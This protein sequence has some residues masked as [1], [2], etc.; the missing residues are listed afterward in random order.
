MEWKEV[1]PSDKQSLCR[2]IQ[3]IKLMITNKSRK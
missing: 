3:I 2:I 1:F